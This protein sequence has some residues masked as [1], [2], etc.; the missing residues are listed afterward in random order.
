[1]PPKAI[2]PVVLVLALLA[3]GC[4]PSEDPPLGAKLLSFKLTDEGCEPHDA[5]VPAGPVT[6]EAEGASSSVTE[7]EV[8][9][10]ETIVGVSEVV[11]DGLTGRFSLTLEPGRYTLRC[12][13][14]SEEDG[15][16]TV[17]G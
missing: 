8:L 4:G 9:E 10:G 3:G 2:L 12:W 13:N 5:K 14:G 7:I 15:T 16:L 17:T 11:T 1:M 6:F